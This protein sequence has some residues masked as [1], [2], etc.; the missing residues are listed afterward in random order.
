LA[1]AVLALVKPVFTRADNG[2]R[3]SDL[4]LDLT[5]FGGYGRYAQCDNRY[6]V[7]YGGLG[8][9]VRSRS[10]S[11][12]SW[13]VASGASAFDERAL[14]QDDNESPSTQRGVNGG[15]V[16][17]GGWDW[18]HFGFQLG[19]GVH[20]FNDDSDTG[21]Q[22]NG[23]RVALYPA[24]TL[25]LGPNEGL[26]LQCGLLDHLPTNQAIGAELVFADSDAFALGLGV[27]A[28]QY[29]DSAIPMLRAEIP[30]GEGHWLGTRLG[31]AE[32]HGALAWQGQ[33][34]ATFTLDRDPP[35]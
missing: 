22:L 14:P 30:L 18:K 23:S 5:S 27:H 12:L 29:T 33:L 26:S 19:P 10:A 21:L 1:A 4:R 31:A 7:R 20:L 3:E 32:T 17:Q 9:A 16:A 11:G 28:F 13:R 6:A 34:L 15:L 35:R 2:E 24:L 25:R 8:A